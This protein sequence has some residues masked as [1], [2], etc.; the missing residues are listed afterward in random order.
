MSSKSLLM[1]R[2]PLS[3]PAQCLD[4]LSKA[5]HTQAQPYLTRKTCLYRPTTLGS[6]LSGR[7]CWVKGD[8]S[9]LG[10]TAALDSVV[11]GF[12]EATRDSRLSR[13]SGRNVNRFA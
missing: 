11:E 1:H 5:L 4:F 6:K 8:C 10:L 9:I 12:I 7:D 2:S 13:H 3:L